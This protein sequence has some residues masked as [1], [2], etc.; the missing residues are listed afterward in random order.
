MNKSAI[1]ILL[2]AIFIGGFFILYQNR[3]TERN[4]P[5]TSQTDQKTSTKQNWES[6]TDDQAMV[7]VTVTPIGISPES[8]EWKFNVVMSTHSVE[9]DQ[10]MIKSVV[11]VDVQGKEF[12]PLN[13]EGPVGGHHREGLLIFNPITPIPKF[14]ELKIS[15]IG[16]VIRSFNWQLK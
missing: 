8:E 12:K 7:I 6:K 15:G 3:S 16:D 10:D 4:A 9:L 1:I 5:T 13:W 2:L 14:V 11:L